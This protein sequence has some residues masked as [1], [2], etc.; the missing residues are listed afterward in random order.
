MPP[1]ADSQ[2]AAQEALQAIDDASGGLRL[3]WWKG[4]GQDTYDPLAGPTPADP[5][6]APDK[7]PAA[8]LPANP[9]RFTA[10]DLAGRYVSQLII[11]GA[12]IPDG[13]EPELGD[14]T[15]VAG[16][17]WRVI[18]ANPIAPDGETAIIWEVHIERG[19]SA[20]AGAG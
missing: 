9:D 14:R 1:N 11:P 20:N 10:A 8:V 13:W 7:I 12:G 5:A 6:P 18:D 15:Q 17:T 19:G 2:Q 3:D 4:G 16:R